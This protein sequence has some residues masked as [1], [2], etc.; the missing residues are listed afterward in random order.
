MSIDAI[1]SL[2]DVKKEYAEVDVTFFK[3][4]FKCALKT[5]VSMDF[6]LVFLDPKE[7]LSP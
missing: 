1:E 2:L 4:L 5:K 7:K 3:L 6:F